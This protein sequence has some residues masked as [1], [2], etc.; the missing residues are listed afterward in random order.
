MPLRMLK[1]V[2]EMSNKRP[3]AAPSTLQLL[4]PQQTLEKAPLQDLDTPRG[5]NDTSSLEYIWSSCGRKSQLQTNIF[6]FPSV[7]SGRPRGTC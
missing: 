4:E 1:Y 7:L 6:N 2:M 3:T 5:C